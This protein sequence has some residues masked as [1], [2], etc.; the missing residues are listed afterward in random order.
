MGSGDERRCKIIKYSPEVGHSDV[1]LIRRALIKAIET[2]LALK[3]IFKSKIPVVQKHNKIIN[4]MCHVETDE[5]VEHD[6]VLNIVL[7]NMASIDGTP[8]KLVMNTRAEQQ[9]TDENNEQPSSSNAQQK[10]SMDPSTLKDCRQHLYYLTYYYYYVKYYLYH[11]KVTDENNGQASSSSA[12]Q[13]PIVKHPLT[14]KDYCR[15]HVGYPAKLPVLTPALQKIKNEDQVYQNQLL[16][17]NFWSTHLE[18]K[19]NFDILKTQIA[20]SIRNRRYQ[21]KQALMKSAVPSK[22]HPLVICSTTHTPGSS[23]VSKQ[24]EGLNSKKDVVEAEAA[25]KKCSSS[26]ESLHVKQLLRETYSVRRLW[27]EKHCKNK[28]LI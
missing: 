3:A 14:T 15:K 18:T 21:K 2:D 25:L 8:E 13:K 1:E 26:D 23:E 19:N 17:I 16:F 11:F 28:C 12:E 4:E 27:I 5:E 6:S 22:K 24:S 20:T 10:S 7:I 9:A